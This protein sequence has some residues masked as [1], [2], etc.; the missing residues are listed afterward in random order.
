MPTPRSSSPPMDATHFYLRLPLV[1]PPKTAEDHLIF[2]V[3]S[4]PKICI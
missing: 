4:S 2:G 3:T 1:D